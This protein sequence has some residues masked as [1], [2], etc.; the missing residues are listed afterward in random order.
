[1]RQCRRVE[2]IPQQGQIKQRRRHQ[3][4]LDHA[5]LAHVQSPRTHPGHGLRPLH[6]DFFLPLLVVIPQLILISGEH[7]FNSQQSVRPLVRHRI[8]Q[9]EHHAW[10]SRVQQ[11]DRQF[12]IIGWPG[13]L[14]ALIGAPVRQVDLPSGSGGWRRGQIVRRASFKRLLQHL[15]PHRH[16]RLLPGCE[17]FVQWQQEFKESLRKVGFGIQISRCMVA[18]LQSSSR[19]IESHDATTP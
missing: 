19:D 18:G 12:R 3:F 13:H 16:Q 10:R 11:L 7:I 6:L 8:L 1:M 4:V 14:I 5:T 15:I 9:I 17:L 2:L